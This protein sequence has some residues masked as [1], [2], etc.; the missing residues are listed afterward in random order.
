MTNRLIAS[1]LYNFKE[2]NHK[3]LAVALLDSNDYFYLADN[4]QNFQGL[5]QVF[6]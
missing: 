6:C 5:E 2:I 3:E 4:L 1:F